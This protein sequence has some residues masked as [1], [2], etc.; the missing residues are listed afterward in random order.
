[1]LD[2]NPS[3][4]EGFF[5]FDHAEVNAVETSSLRELAPLLLTGLAL[6]ARPVVVFQKMCHDQQR[7]VQ[8][9]CWVWWHWAC[10]P[11]GGKRLQR[12]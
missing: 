9:A 1:L 12:G 10:R 2:K 3:I 11:S 4:M 6:F 7:V 8:S 5:V